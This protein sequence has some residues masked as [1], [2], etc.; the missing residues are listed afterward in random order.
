MY[1]GENE[2]FKKKVHTGFRLSMETLAQLD[3]LVEKE[4]QELLDELKHTYKMPNRAIVVNRTKVVEWLIAKHL[5]D[6]ER[7]KVRESM[8]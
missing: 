1:F 8:G 4:E 6:D 3:Y 7:R 2:K 5:T